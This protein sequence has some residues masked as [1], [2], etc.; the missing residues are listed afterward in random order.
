M[1]ILPEQAEKR[2][3]KRITHPVA[4]GGIHKKSVYGN[5]PLQVRPSRVT[6]REPAQKKGDR[7]L[8]GW[9]FFC[10]VISYYGEKSVIFGKKE[11]G[12]S[13]P[14]RTRSSSP[15]Q[16]V[17]LR[18]FKTQFK[19]IISALRRRVARQS[20]SSTA[21]SSVASSTA[22]SVVAAIA[23]AA[24]ATTAT[25]STWPLTSLLH[26]R[27]LPLLPP[28]ARGRPSFVASSATN[29]AQA[30]AH[31]MLKPECAYTEPGI[32]VLVGITKQ[33]QIKR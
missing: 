24:I 19:S 1:R 9:L 28:A 2:V 7:G 25:A 4:L 5:R 31:C 20:S 32:V 27:F 23:T 26:P 29:I 8:R 30:R 33:W 11:A 10:L 6:P 12:C 22:T 3:R 21:A 18:L 15:Q 13:A 16:A 17:A 14:G